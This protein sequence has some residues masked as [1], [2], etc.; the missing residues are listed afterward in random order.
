[1]KTKVIPYRDIQETMDLIKIQIADSLKYSKQWIEAYNIKSVSELFYE[2]Q[3]QTTFKHDPKG[4][5][6]LQSMQTLF[7]NNYWG[8]AGS[9]DCD[10]FVISVT[11]CCI[12]LNFNTEIV[13][14]GR[15]PD[16]PVHIYNLVENIPFD[17]TERNL[18][19]ERFYKYTQ[20]LPV[21]ASRI[22]RIKPKTQLNKILRART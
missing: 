10:C 1:M 18:G 11:A 14:A 16:K 19:D 12:N 4:T 9:G 7:S 3:D 6:L 2:L 20:I 17:L 22:K 15:S 21:N 8:V 13:L 5:E